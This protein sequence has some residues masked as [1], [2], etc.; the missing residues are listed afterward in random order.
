[1][2]LMYNKLYALFDYKRSA[3][4]LGGEN[5]ATVN[6]DTFVSS[7]FY[8]EWLWGSPCFPFVDGLV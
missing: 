7:D 6:Y 2:K 5:Q 3:P 8:I 1:M 4:E